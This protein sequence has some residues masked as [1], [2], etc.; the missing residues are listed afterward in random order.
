MPSGPLYVFVC[1]A[2]TGGFILV[3]P[4]TGRGLTVKTMSSLVK[5]FVHWPESWT[6]RRRTAVPNPFVRFTLIGRLVH[7]LPQELVPTI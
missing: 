2:T 5:L 4:H 6:V 1:P 3:I 7:P